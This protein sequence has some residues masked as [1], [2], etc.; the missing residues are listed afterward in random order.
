MA[1]DIRVLVPR[2]RRALSADEATVSDDEVK[3]LVADAIADVILYTGSAFGRT[4]NVTEVD[5]DTNAP[6]EY[7]VD[8]DLALPEQSVIATQ[9]ALNYFFHT[10]SD[11]LVSEK[12]SDEAQTWEYQRSANLYT[13]R[14]KLLIDERDRA[15][16]AVGGGA[17]MSAYVSFLAVRDPY[18]AAL[19]E[20]WVAGLPGGGQED[21]RFGP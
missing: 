7:E 9:A 15:L 18:T 17:Q 21:Y 2:V 6:S 5:P 10:F 16:E 20:P 3:D 13:Q 1:Q 14:F 19:I 4:L 11:V 12:I 8:P